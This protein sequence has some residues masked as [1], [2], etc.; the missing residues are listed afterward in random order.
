MSRTFT[1][2][3]SS[4]TESTVWCE[5]D[6]TRLVWVCMLAMADRNGRVW[7]SVP[8]LANRAR[9][10]VDDCRLA[11]ETF[12]AP[13]PDSRTP[14]FE[15][16]RIEPIDGGWRLLNHEKYRA[17]R[18]EET[19]LEAKRNYINTRRAAERAAKAVEQSRSG[20]GCVGRGR[21]NAEAEAEAES[22]TKVKDI[23][24]PT[25]PHPPAEL[26]GRK[27]R[28]KVAV[29]RPD[30]VDQQVWDDW[31]T[32]RKQ[33]TAAVT[34]TVLDGA[35][36][37]AALAHMGLQAFL[38]VWC[39]RG[40]TGLEAAWL[41]PDERTGG[42]APAA[43]LSPTEQAKREWWQKNHPNLVPKDEPPDPWKEHPER[44]IDVDTPRISDESDD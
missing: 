30:D 1:K 24:E 33:K 5:P 42:Q 18:D 27:T 39:R 16:R 17:I 7:A 44:T 28:A 23:S 9:V 40:S 25:V 37:Q 2:L 13:D 38:E 3:F 35:R 19:T 32:L 4:I 8:G 34:V 21:D 26:P 10:P 36:K 43:R 14:D 20:V 31:L 29:I 12:L 11:L 22:Q 6:R 15:G 41:K